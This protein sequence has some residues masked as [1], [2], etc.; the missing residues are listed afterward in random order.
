VTPLPPYPQWART[1]KLVGL[2]TLQ[3]TVDA[4]GGVRDISVE[5]VEGDERFGPVA[6]EAVSGWKFQPGTYEG[7]KV[8]VL[9]SQRVRFRLVD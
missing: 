7:K 3:F 9:V 5:S 4:E 1:R 2:V 8:A 6:V